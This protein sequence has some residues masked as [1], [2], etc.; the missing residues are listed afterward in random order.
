[1]FS[2]SCLFT[3]FLIALGVVWVPELIIELHLSITPGA[4]EL[5]VLFK[6][7][8]VLYTV[9][10][11]QVKNQMGRQE[12]KLIIRSLKTSGK[13]FCTFSKVFYSLVEVTFLKKIGPF[14]VQFL[15]QSINFVRYHDLSAY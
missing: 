2:Y 4:N 10:Q 13:M 6:T 7:T 5:N 14:V 1:M 15:E 12:R 3:V 9:K 8:A 11:C